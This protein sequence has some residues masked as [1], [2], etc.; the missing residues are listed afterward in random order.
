MNKNIHSKAKLKNQKYNVEV[1]C[2]LTLMHKSMSVVKLDLGK[3]QETTIDYN[4]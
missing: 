1:K 2:F 4:K 3:L